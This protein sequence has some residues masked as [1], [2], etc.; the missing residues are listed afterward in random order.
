[1]PESPETWLHLIYKRRKWEAA[2]QKE[3]H[4]QTVDLDEWDM[5]TVRQVRM[6]GVLDERWG[7]ENIKQ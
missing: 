2:R 5:E 3:E 6:A 1:M 7:R 4:S